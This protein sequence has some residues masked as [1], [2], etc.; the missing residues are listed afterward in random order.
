[1]SPQA[2]AGLL[3]TALALVRDGAGEFSDQA[4]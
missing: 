4:A 1:V 2:G 3:L